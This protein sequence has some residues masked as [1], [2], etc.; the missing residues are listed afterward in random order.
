AGPGQLDDLLTDIGFP[1]A[2]DIDRLL[3]ALASATAPEAVTVAD[4][5]RAAAHRLRGRP[6]G[7]AASCFELSAR[8]YGHDELADQIAGLPFDRP[9][10]IPWGHWTALS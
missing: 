8:Q 9:W 2:A 4:T 7:E 1:L 6:A 10:T 5:Y 3:P